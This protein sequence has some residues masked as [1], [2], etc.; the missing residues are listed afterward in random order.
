MDKLQAMQVF[1]RVVDG[2]G[3]TRAAEFLHMPKATV[4]TLIKSLET[5]L[6]VRLL[7]RTTRRVSVTA[8]GAAYY[9]RCLRILAEV[10]E[11]ESALSS[12]KASPS[13]LLRVDVP[14][15]FGR[16]FLVPALPDFFEQYPDIRLKLGCSDRPVD[17]IEEGV[18]CVVRG[19]DQP[20]SSLVARR[21]ATLDFVTCAT[22]EYLQR[23][24][25]PEH[26]E[27]LRRH[28]CLSY[29]SAKTG[30]TFRWDYTRGEERIELALDGPIALND[31]EA[32]F[33]AGLTGLGIIQTTPYFLARAG[34]RLQRILPDWRSDPLPVWIMYPQNRHLSTKVR[35][36]VDW[37][38]E[39]FTRKFH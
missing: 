8:D 2:G 17:L 11:T 18:D 35:V 13:G 1:V 19:G 30:Q 16:R 31:G 37:I 28:R 4:T 36:F 3:F 29:F 33:E 22:P 24:G 12:A 9:E 26:P 15:T 10:E 27:D 20:D 25:E 23:Y 14:A 38:A 21:V 6:G 34:T 5:H 39:L 7:N 32:Y